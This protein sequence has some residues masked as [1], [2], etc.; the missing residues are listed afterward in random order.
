MIHLE[1]ETELSRSYSINE[2]LIRLL[3]KAEKEPDGI[4]Q[5]FRV[6]YIASINREKKTTW[7][8]FEKGTIVRLKGNNY[9]IV[10]K[11]QEE[12]SE[13]IK[14]VWWKKGKEDI[15]WWDKQFRKRKKEFIDE[16]ISYPLE[17][18]KPIGIEPV[19][20]FIPGRTFIRMEE[21][22][23][24]IL[25]KNEVVQL[26]NN[27]IFFMY[28]EEDR[29]YHLVRPGEE[30][31]FPSESFPGK[32]IGHII[33][34]PTRS[35]L[36]AA[37]NRSKRELVVSAKIF[38]GKIGIK[39]LLEK[40]K[41][42]EN[43]TDELRAKFEIS[44]GKQTHSKRDFE[45]AWEEAYAELIESKKHTEGIWG[46]RIEDRVIQWEGIEVYIKDKQDVRYEY[47]HGKIKDLDLDPEKPGLIIE[48]ESGETQAYERGE[49]ETKQISKIKLIE[50]SETTSYEV[51]EDG[52][53]YKAFVGFK[54]KK[55]AKSWCK[56]LKRELG[57]ISDPVES[58]KEWSPTKSKYY[59]IASKPKQK[60]LKGRLKRLNKVSEWDLQQPGSKPSRL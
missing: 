42:G 26:G 8:P 21:K 37:K 14:I 7:H 29:L 6:K 57:W 34:G 9:G 39:R 52:K 22:T 33:E 16:R 43:P 36:E 13:P 46:Y 10:E 58:S 2:Q 45:S 32:A 1:K 5:V 41:E 60:T 54:T 55:L 12:D 35:Q 59:C 53:Y 30:W 27:D 44:L 23:S 4:R 20:E 17:Y 19:K 3:T 56:N 31:I 47:L 51:S 25:E 15:P 50:I 24:V 48:W 40:I 18:L 11:I 49:L 38:L 28:K